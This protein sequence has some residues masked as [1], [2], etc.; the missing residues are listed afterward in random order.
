MNTV[1]YITSLEELQDWLETQTPIIRMA[2]AA[3]TAF[4]V[5]PVVYANGWPESVIES[6]AT[7]LGLRS[8][9][10]LQCYMHFETPDLRDT[11]ASLRTYGVVTESTARLAALR[12]MITA[13]G[14]IEARI[15][16]NK[17]GAGPYGAG[18]FNSDISHELDSSEATTEAVRSALLAIKL[19]KRRRADEERIWQ[20]I[21]SD[22]E[23]AFHRFGKVQGDLG[24]LTGL[25]PV[26]VVTPPLH[27]AFSP[28]RHWS[29]WS[30]WYERAMAG[31]PL[32]WELQR[33][34]ALIPDAIWQQGPEAVALRIAEIEADYFAKLPLAEKIENDPAT[35][36]F[37]TV[38]LEVQRP[39]L[40]GALLIHVSDALED[41]L[42]LPGNGISER[43]RETR[44]LHRALRR[45]GNDP[46]Q[47]EVSFASVHAGLQRQFISGELPQSED[48]IALKGALE[49]A[50]NGIRATHPEVAENRRLLDGM[51]VRALPQDAVQSLQKALPVLAAISDDALAEEWQ[52]DI[53]KL[54]NDATQPLPSGAPP[55]P[56]LDESL[57]I[58]KRSAEIARLLR[59]EEVRERVAARLKGFKE[60]PEFMIMEVIAVVS[61][62]VG[63]GIVL[64]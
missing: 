63:L 13:Y 53:P 12:A 21:L 46:Q 37:Y 30:R 7:L 50:L 49:E 41:T 8:L 20:S 2:I 40:Y 36:A 43:S 54:I 45:Y 32:P 29:F 51:C 56:G 23:N 16:P 58:V 19:L 6:K 10:T 5:L 17:F 35:G 27:A 14:S 3:R 57:R 48:N 34:I 11:A 42:S 1:S 18:D 64:F 26:K 47:L 4:R 22:C 24:I 33:E 15:E 55:L 60:S 31:D 28:P 61:G 39:Q 25:D 38:P 44:A 59:R 9:F 62:I 52:H